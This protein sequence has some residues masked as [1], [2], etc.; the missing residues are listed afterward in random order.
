MD[1]NILQ[2]NIIHAWTKCYNNHIFLEN[3]DN[4]SIVIHDNLLNNN[5]IKK[6]YYIDNTDNALI[7]VNTK[8][9]HLIMHRCN[10]IT[11]I[12]NSVL[13]SGLDIFHSNNISIINNIPCKAEYSFC[14]GENCVFTF[15][16]TDIEIRLC[17]QA[18]YNL[19]IK[20]VNERKPYRGCLNLF[21]AEPIYFFINNNTACINGFDTV[22]GNFTLTN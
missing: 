8:I 20:L 19:I 7:Y 18:V 6:T 17:M 11:L 22:Y 1:P 9:N 16:T 15:N 21:R 12:I 10:N 13:I 14:F 2:N 4:E 3:K 5:L